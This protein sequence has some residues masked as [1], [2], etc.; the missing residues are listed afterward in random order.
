MDSKTGG[1]AA[2]DQVKLIMQNT[3]Q[4]NGMSSAIDQNRRTA[5]YK[6]NI[7][8]YDLIEGITTEYAVRLLSS[9]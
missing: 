5:N 4:V 9:L 8:N 3:S 6:P 7:W 2:D 1:L